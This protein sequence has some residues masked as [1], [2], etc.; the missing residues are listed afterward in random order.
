MYCSK[1]G[2]SLAPGA[3][4]CSVCGQP[5]VLG[6]AP[7]TSPVL[8]LLAAS[9]TRPIVRVS[10]AGFWLRFIA[11]VMDGLILGLLF[12]GSLLAIIIMSGV[13]S[14]LAH[15]HS[16]EDVSDAA[17]VIGIGFLVAYGVAVFCGVWLY[18][19]L[20]ESSGWQATLGKKMLGLKVTDSHGQRVSFLRATGRYFAK[21][22]SGLIPFSYIMAG[23]TE[24]KQALHDMIADCLVLRND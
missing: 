19:A 21:I 5:A 4:F 11:H 22:V 12:M 23:F 6:A 2:N 10:Y 3:T 7:G 18:S 24:K 14:T 1:C 16:G 13:G 20:S 15:I 17:T 9:V 8:A